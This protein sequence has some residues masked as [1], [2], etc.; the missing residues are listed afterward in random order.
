VTRDVAGFQIGGIK[1]A[2][3]GVYM[4]VS[5]EAPSTA[6]ITRV[7]GDAERI[8]Y[9]L[10]NRLAAIDPNM[11]EVSTLQSLV[12]TD[13][14][15][16]GISFWLTLV[17]GS[18]ALAL[19]LSG[20]FSVLSYLVEQRTRGSAYAWRSAQRTAASAG[21]V[22]QSARPSASACCSAAPSRWGS[23]P[24]CSPAA[25]E[26]IAATVQLFDPIAAPATRRRAAAAVA[27]ALRAGRVNPLAA[28]RQD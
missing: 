25:A 15:I 10:V 20:L 4:P 3:A 28:L 5:A 19:T 17:L 16:L 18:L 26:Q 11:A 21:R 13:T 22:W 9:A 7:R 23:T 27:P 14:Y 2:G 1:L 12:R 24:R 6:L 8:R